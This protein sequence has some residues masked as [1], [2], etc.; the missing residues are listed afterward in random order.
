MQEDRIRALEERV[1]SLEKEVLRLSDYVISEIKDVNKASNYVIPKEIPEK[2]IPEKE[3]PIC[4]ESIK[5]EQEISLKKAATYD[6]KIYSGRVPEMEAEVSVKD[7]PVMETKGS[8]TV[9]TPEAKNILVK[10]NKISSEEKKSLK[11]G[12]SFVGIYLIGA[13]ASLLIFIGAVFFITLI[14]DKISPQIKVICIFGIGFL[15]FG[16]GFRLSRKEKSPISSILLGTGTGLVY[17]G[18]FALDFAFGLIHHRVA[19][20]LC[21]LWF[22]M[23]LISHHYIQRFF[24]IIIA[25]IGAYIGFAA[26]LIKLNTLEDATFLLIAMSIVALTII[27]TLRKSKWY[28]FGILM[29]CLIY[30]SFLY[31][32]I[33]LTLQF[34]T[35]FNDFFII[36]IIC[37]GAI[38]LLKNLWYYEMNVYRR[39]DESLVSAICYS[40]IL[41]LWLLLR[42]DT[43]GDV[44]ITWLQIAWVMLGIYVVQ[45][46]INALLYKEIYERLAYYHLLFIYI[47]GGMILYDKIDIF[48]G[49][50]GIL[51]ILFVQRYIGEKNTDGDKIN[52]KYILLFL[53]IDNLL[54][55]ISIPRAVLLFVAIDVLGIL[56]LVQS[57][58]RWRTSL[59][60]KNGII[61][62]LMFNA[63]FVGKHIS[64]LILGSNFIGYSLVVIHI[65]A[66]ICLALIYISGYLKNIKDKDGIEEKA[67][68]RYQ[69]FK[70]WIQAVFVISTIGAYVNEYRLVGRSLMIICGLNILLSMFITYLTILENDAKSAETEGLLYLLRFILFIYKPQYLLCL[71]LTNFIL[72]AVGGKKEALSK[73]KLI[74]LTGILV[75][76][77]I[78]GVYLVDTYDWDIHILALGAICG[79]VHLL[80]LP[81]IKA[82]KPENMKHSP[83]PVYEEIF[84]VLGII[85]LNTEY[86]SLIRVLLSLLLLIYTISLMRVKSEKKTGWQEALISIRFLALTWSVIHAFLNL[87]VYSVIYSVSG[88]MIAI[89]S[90]S[91]GF[92]YRLKGLRHFGLGL[93]I[94]MVLK[95]I[96]VDVR[97][98]DSIFR[99]LSFI[100]GGILCLAISMIYHKFNKREEM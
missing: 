73:C 69:V 38:T 14:W 77:V 53:L 19:L 100:A 61:S 72:Y 27:F 66:V 79:I 2:E 31:I 88:L 46:I 7:K 93:A 70:L 41:C 35:Y 62:L 30:I 25:Y 12:E 51:L 11:S 3:K 42:M 90:I 21:I 76:Y 37:V 59:R 55:Y 71:A 22:V 67:C 49:S 13:L 60:A 81:Y 95:F 48:S 82:Y 57:D 5:T 94:L 8:Q 64:V 78:F 65:I 86:D 9:A 44:T 47:S 10:E 68:K 45:Y 32:P 50:V 26:E 87:E 74:S 16:L 52:K 39:K 84:Y 23:I 36:E 15:L 28:I 6:F 1:S 97:G 18:I 54:L 34:G 56:Y 24:N 80:I 92:L 89:S 98:T 58:E 43:I 99:V 33:F 17:I 96:L 40:W 63:P 4:R 20:C 83:I 75:S 85:V 91:L 29:D